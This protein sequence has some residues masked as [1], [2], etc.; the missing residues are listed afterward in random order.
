MTKIILIHNIAANVCD[1]K[2]FGLSASS[3]LVCQSSLQ[4]NIPTDMGGVE[5]FKL[6]SQ[7]GQAVLQ[8]VCLWTENLVKFGI[9]LW[10]IFLYFS[11]FLCS[12]Q[13]RLILI[14]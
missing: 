2:Q 14:D 4:W 9:K 6:C 10:V 1:S 7:T 13:F 11:L 5:T 3:T 12:K 8:A